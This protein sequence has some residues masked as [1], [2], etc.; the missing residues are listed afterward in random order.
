MW[1]KYYKWSEESNSFIECDLENPSKQGKEEIG[2]KVFKT[3][4]PDNPKIIIDSVGP[5]YSDE[6]H[7]EE[8][9]FVP[10]VVNIKNAINSIINKDP[11]H[12][13][14]TIEVYKKWNGK[15]EDKI[16]AKYNYEY[17]VITKGSELPEDT[18]VEL[19]FIHGWWWVMDYYLFVVE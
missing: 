10:K 11:K 9:H 17:W 5:T 1:E 13:W 7:R 2:N 12:E 19:W 14:W 6:T 18:K 4:Q 3:L 15:T 8:C 16:L